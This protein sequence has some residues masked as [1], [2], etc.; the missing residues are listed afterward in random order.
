MFFLVGIGLK[1]RHITSE[2]IETLKKCEKIFAEEYTSEYCEGTLEE[3]EKK[4]GGKKIELLNREAIEIGFDFSSEAVRKKNVALLVFGNPL[5]ATTHIQL[6][7]DA[8]EKKVETKVIP[9]ISIT[10]MLAKSGLDEYRF[11]RTATICYHTENFT[12]DSFY[13]QIKLNQSIGLHTLCLLDIKKDD[14]EKKLM[15]CAE[16]IA[17]LEKIAA[18]KNEK[19]N[20]SYVA[21]LALGAEKEKI[22]FGKKEIESAKE[23][24]KLFPQSLIVCGKLTEK[25]KEALEKLHCAKISENPQKTRLE[26][27]VEKYEA[28]TKKALAEIIFEKEISEKERKMGEAFLEMA[29]NYFSDGK[30][31]KEKGDFLTALASFSYAHAWLDAGVRAKIFHAE[32]DQLFTL[33]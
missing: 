4:L 30:H 16:G 31:F 17:V 22:I 6:L 2:A 11:G 27:K 23:T 21:L 19:T 14:K 32:D 15:N 9:G 28:L 3:I 5:T 24:Q 1:P 8:K 12:P 7:I 29:K 18:E 20:W 26:E 25:E 33:P 13:E 10:N